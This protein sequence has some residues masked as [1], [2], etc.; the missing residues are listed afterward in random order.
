MVRVSRRFIQIVSENVR[1]GVASSSYFS[2][3]RNQK[4]R[5]SFISVFPVEEGRANR[6]G[7]LNEMKND[8]CPT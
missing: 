4:P 1:L 5:M 2:A 6:I 3:I 7:R 8:L